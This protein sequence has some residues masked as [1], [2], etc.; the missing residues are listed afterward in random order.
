MEEGKRR[1]PNDHLLIFQELLL[2]NLWY[3][4]TVAEARNHSYLGGRDWKDH[5]SRPAGTKKFMKPHL[6]KLL[7]QWGM[8]VIPATVRKHK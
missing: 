8:H 7:D 5:I 1:N 4:D 2:L 6:N 3:P